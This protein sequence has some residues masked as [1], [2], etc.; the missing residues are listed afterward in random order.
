MIN[1]ELEEKGNIQDKERRPTRNF[2]VAKAY[3]FRNIQNLVQRLRRDKLKAN[4]VE[5]MACPS[6]KRV[7]EFNIH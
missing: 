1:I 2:T 6:G 5:V 7:F 4:F 3:G